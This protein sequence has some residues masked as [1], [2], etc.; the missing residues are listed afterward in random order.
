MMISYKAILTLCLCLAGLVLMSGQNTYASNGMNMIGFG[1]A[2][3]AMGGADL[4]MTGSHTMNI[5]P[6]GI[7]AG[8]LKE[9]SFGFSP[10]W[11][12]LNHSDN[13]GNN[14][15][16]V[17]DRVPMPF[18]A[19]THPVRQVTFGLGM[20]V[21]GGMG[22]EYPDLVTPFAA[23]L[24]SGQVPP[25]AFDGSVVPA[26]DDMRT[27]VMH[28]KLTPTVAWRAT[29]D[30][31]LGAS[32]NV[33]Y[34]RMDMKFFPETS[35]MVN[36]G[37]LVLRFS[38]MEMEDVSGMGY[39]LR[40]GF[41]YR[42]GVLELGG[43]YC[44]ESDLDLDGG[45]MNLNLS[46]MGA[47]KVA[48]DATISGFAWPQ[49]VGMG[50]AY[51]V[52]PWLLVAAD[53]DWVN[54]SGAIDQLTVNLSNPDKGQAPAT[55]LVPFDMGWEDQWVYALGVELTPVVD[56]TWRMG[57]NHGKSPIPDA[58]LKP[59]FPAIGEDHITGGVGYRIGSW[60]IDAG[61]ERVIETE[62]INNSDNMANNPLGQGSQETLSQLMAHFMVRRTFR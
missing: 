17:L 62:K 31:T 34:A 59:L 44:T 28:A 46:A 60:S 39:G 19:Y 53:V 33:C 25:G 48:Y 41:Q 45:T 22:A 49:Q 58:G 2:S 6:A 15:E 1:A 14:K 61:L 16:D 29:S 40:L 47:G 37:P 23:M 11:P 9:L 36:Q 7:G 42:S 8:S 18:L 51:Q 52:K 20:F 26:T 38:G 56:W 13:L 55:G 5:N 54:W 10:M 27:R 24:A 57:Y 32:V 30:L 35:V 12:S 50:G 43:A 21:Q 4:T 3:T